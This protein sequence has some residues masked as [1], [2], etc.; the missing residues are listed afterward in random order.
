MAK[1][2]AKLLLLWRC[3]LDLDFDDDPSRVDD[4]ANLSESDSP[5]D[6]MGV[7]I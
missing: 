7:M 3:S 5:T 6:V 1:G 4:D 2:D